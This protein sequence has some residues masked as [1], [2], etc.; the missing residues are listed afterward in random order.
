MSMRKLIALVEAKN[1]VG[2]SPQSW[3]IYQPDEDEDEADSEYAGYRIVASALNTAAS[4]AVAKISK[5]NGWQ[6]SGSISQMIRDAMDD[7]FN[8]VADKYSKYGVYDGEVERQWRNL[9]IDGVLAAKPFED[10]KIMKA[11]IINNW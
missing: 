2:L 8:P 6:D 11:D 3:E 9:V 1:D 10:N 5:A 4:K 7:F